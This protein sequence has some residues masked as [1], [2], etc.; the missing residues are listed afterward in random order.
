MSNFKFQLNDTVKITASG[1]T[2]TI[3]SRAEHTTGTNNYR[4]HYKAAD[5]RAVEAW[6]D[7]CDLASD[8]SSEDVQF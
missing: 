8:L 1:E 5:G 6:W 3:K 7:E 2:G 4:I